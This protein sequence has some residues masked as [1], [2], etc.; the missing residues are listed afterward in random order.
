MLYH[1]SP[2][3]NLKELDP[4]MNESTHLKSL[5]KYVYASDDKSYSAG[6]C[7]TWNSRDGIRYGQSGDDEPWMLEIPKRHLNRL[8]GSCSIYFL[9]PKDFRKVRGISTPE[10]YSKNIVKVI[11]EEKYKTAL[12]CLKKNNVEIKVI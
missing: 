1:A 12:G 3:Q 11:S 10:F 4:E 2:I 9:D 8:K 6:F 5:R 7:F